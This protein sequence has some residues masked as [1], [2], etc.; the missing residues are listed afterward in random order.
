MGQDDGRGM[1]RW[2]W[3]D[4]RGTMDVGRWTWDDGR[5]MMD[6]GRWIWDITGVARRYVL[7]GVHLLEQWH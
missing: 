1:G 6:V 3:D 4:G 7:T 2:T 5:G